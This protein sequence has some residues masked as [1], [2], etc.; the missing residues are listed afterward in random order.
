M[1]FSLNETSL[2]YQENCF[3]TEEATV[4]NHYNLE[5]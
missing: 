2:T 5:D 3:N 4:C 1:A